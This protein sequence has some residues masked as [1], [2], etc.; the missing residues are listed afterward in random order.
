MK[1]KSKRSPQGASELLAQVSLDCALGDSASPD[2]LRKVRAGL[3]QLAA[4]VEGSP[5]QAA[6]MLALAAIDELDSAQDPSGFARL[7]E[8]LAT[9]QRELE[10]APSAASA[11]GASKPPRASKP[12]AGRVSQGPGEPV[13]ERDAE[14]VE[15]FADF[16]A[17]SLEGLDRVDAILL[18]GEHSAP[19]SEQ[20]NALFRVFHTIKGVSGF[21]NV[22]EVTRLAHVT[23]ALLDQ[24]RQGNLEL[25]GE[26]LDAVF[27][28]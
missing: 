5:P 26:A 18:A 27:E 20:V 22:S 1:S 25:A 15:L 10:K 7:A 8:L 28:S 3:E 4:I 11:P 16:A 13:A 23:E 21:L 12:A 24:V 19:D 2:T 6:V 9:V 14:M 17:E